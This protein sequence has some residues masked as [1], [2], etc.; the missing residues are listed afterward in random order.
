E[1][2]SPEDLADLLLLLARNLGDLLALPLPLAGPGVGLAL[3][4]E[5][6]A[7][8]HRDG[9][10]GQLRNA[11]DEDDACVRDGAGE[12]GRERE[13]DGEAV[14]HPEDDVAHDLG[15]REVRLHVVVAGPGAGRALRVRGRYFFRLFRR[16]GFVCQISRLFVSARSSVATRET[17]ASATSSG[18]I[19][20]D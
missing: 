7:E 3:G 10:G 9:A 8:S 11:R 5:V 14:G 6:A 19:A 20:R 16:H 2:P 13:G 4:G 1:T 17:T 12:A 18:W 15:P